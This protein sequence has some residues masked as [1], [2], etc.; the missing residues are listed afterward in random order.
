MVRLHLCARAAGLALRTGP[1]AAG[2]AAALD[3]AQSE[4]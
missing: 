1:D 4:F 2:A 3:L